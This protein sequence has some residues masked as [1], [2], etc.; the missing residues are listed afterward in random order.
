V[1]LQLLGADLT[2]PG[3]VA[4]DHQWGHH[5]ETT[6]LHRYLVEHDLFDPANPPL[7]P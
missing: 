4:G 3:Q 7:E 1:Q 6:P 5:P 2:A